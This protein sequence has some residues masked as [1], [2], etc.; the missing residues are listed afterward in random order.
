ML[1]T[2][3]ALHRVID[4]QKVISDCFMVT[5]D[6]RAL[7]PPP[8]VETYSIT[9][10]MMLP[11]FRMSK[12]FFS[13]TLNVEKRR[14]ILFEDADYQVSDPTDLGENLDYNLFNIITDIVRKCWRAKV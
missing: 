6:N 3:P 1:D 10:L 7:N 14:S 12:D 13:R 8:I 11:S 9:P 4:L 2:R 5:Q